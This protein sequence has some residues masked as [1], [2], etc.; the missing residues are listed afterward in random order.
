MIRLATETDLAAVNDL[1]NHYVLHSTCTYQVVP[2]TIEDRRQW[3]QHHGAPHP[4]VV[5]ED[6]G[7]V[8]GW[9][10]LSA[11]HARCA[12]RH[13]V[14][15]SVY[16]HHEF[17]RRGIGSA[18]LEDLISRAKALGH[19]VIIAGIDGEQTGSIALHTRFGF[20]PVG[21]FRQVGF[22]FNRWLD[23]VYLELILARG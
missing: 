15:N 20:Q 10:S 7:Q 11:F 9:G 6:H 3:F 1:Y 2:E 23:V 22:K 14:E 8:V 18:L 17:Q 21:C 5:A 13:T 12:Y 19:H 16:V 4:V